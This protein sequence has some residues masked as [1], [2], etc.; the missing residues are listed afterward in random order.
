MFEIITTYY[1]AIEPEREEENIQCLINNLKHPL[2]TGV[3]LFLQSK[4]FPNVTQN[5]KL[6]Y[7]EHGRR[8]SFSE[9]F[10]Y[11]N[12]LGA[13]TIKVVANSDIYFD[14]T[15]RLVGKALKKWDV[16]ALTRWD[17]REDGTLDFYNNFKSQ[18]VWIFQ[19]QIKHSIGN[20]HIGRHGCDNR[21]VF[22]LKNYKYKIG[23]P[24][25]S[26]KAIH[27]HQS[28]LRSYFNN[29][30]YERVPA[31][32]GYVLPIS[33]NGRVNGSQKRNFINGR[34]RYYKSLSNGTLPGVD[35]TVFTKIWAFILSKY[36]AQKSKLIL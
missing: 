18:D 16:L 32:F 15:L 7:V 30:N 12:T 29:P 6:T 24:S 28:A 26:I 21:L 34:Y 4:E 1:K 20:Y 10:G 33:L 31:P 23:N 25:F 17:L 19:K 13:N 8:P 5:D 14:D 35:S 3:H 27:V 36:Y 22:E 9:L 11:G 2:I